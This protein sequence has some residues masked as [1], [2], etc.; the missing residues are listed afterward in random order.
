MRCRG[1]LLAADVFRRLF[2]LR[3]RRRRL[4]GE[5]T[6]FRG[7]E[8]EKFDATPDVAFLFGDDRNLLC[9]DQVR[10]DVSKQTLGLLEVLECLREIVAGG[11]GHAGS[12]KHPD[13][14]MS[15]SGSHE[16]GAGYSVERG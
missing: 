8:L 12:L 1:V 3:L 7:D 4:C 13:R 2:R 14:A 15:T 11:F 9:S 16:P 6:R 10:V 5:T